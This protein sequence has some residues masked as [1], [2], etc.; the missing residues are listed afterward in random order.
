[1]IPVSLY[2]FGKCLLANS[3]GR[4]FIPFSEHNPEK[5]PFHRRFYSLEGEGKK[6][7]SNKGVEESTENCQENCKEKVDADT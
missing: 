1:M 7:L 2:G 4:L 5:S 6:T 3:V